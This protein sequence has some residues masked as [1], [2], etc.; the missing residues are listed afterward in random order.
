MTQW[1]FIICN[2]HSEKLNMIICYNKELIIDLHGFLHQYS[3]FNVLANATYL[4]ILTEESGQCGSNQLNFFSLQLSLLS[5]D[6]AHH[7]LH[8]SHIVL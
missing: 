8:L 7:L 4:Q 1:L 3:R 5:E 6:K 2:D